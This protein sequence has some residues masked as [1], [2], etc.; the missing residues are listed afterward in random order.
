MSSSDTNTSNNNNN[1]KK[2]QMHTVCLEW[3]GGRQNVEVLSDL[4]WRAFLQQVVHITGIMDEQE[5]ELRT[6]GPR[7]AL[8]ECQDDDD[9]DDAT[10]TLVSAV[11]PDRRTLVHCRRRA[12]SSSTENDKKRGAPMV[13]KNSQQPKKPRAPNVVDLTD[14]NGKHLDTTDSRQ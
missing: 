9:D 2:K 1:K 7:R 12:A 10:Q 5:L 3:P 14:D 6:G 11:L 8:L 4:P 13:H